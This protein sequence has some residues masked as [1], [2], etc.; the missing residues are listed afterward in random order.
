MAD[1]DARNAVSC[2]STSIESPAMP[3]SIQFPAGPVA[4][5][6]E[7][8]PQRLW[9]MF[10]GYSAYQSGVLTRDGKQHPYRLMTIRGNPHL[11]WFAP[12]AQYSFGQTERIS[13]WLMMTFSTSKV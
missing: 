11:L 5:V 9:T 12:K 10:E 4:A 13:K 8:V 1:S 3:R 6:A 2:D 7:R